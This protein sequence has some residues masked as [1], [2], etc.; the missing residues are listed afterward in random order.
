[1]QPTAIGQRLAA[2]IADR[3]ASADKLRQEGNKLFKEGEW[4][5]AI[6]KYHHSLMYTKGILDKFEAL[7]GVQEV[8]RV[9]A[10]PQ[11][12]AAARELSATVSNNLAGMAVTV[13]ILYSK[14]LLWWQ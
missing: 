2:R 7:P 10:T 13:L 4:K 11:E 6:K 12:E 14:L 3:L 1:M 9:K 8:T 5:K